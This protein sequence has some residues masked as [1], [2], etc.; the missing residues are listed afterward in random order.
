[1][2]KNFILI[3]KAVSIAVQI[4]VTS[5]SSEISV[6]IFNHFSIPGGG[7]SAS[8]TDTKREKI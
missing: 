1:V 4:P 5:G 7:F 8:V 2:K 3:S 6:L